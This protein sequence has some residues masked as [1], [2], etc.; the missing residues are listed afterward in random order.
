K[1]R[2]GYCCNGMW[3]SAEALLW[4]FRDPGLPPVASA[5]G[6]GIVGAPTTTTVVEGADLDVNP[7]AGAR[8]SA[9][10]WINSDR[11]MSIE[12][13]GFVT[14][15]GG[16][17]VSLLSTAAQPVFI[18]FL[19][20]ANAESALPTTAGG[21]VVVNGAERLWGVECNFV[22][23]SELCCHDVALFFGYRY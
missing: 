13:T 5:G 12:A 8:A 9:G 17:N 23:L 15:R 7:L 4:W 18:P 3:F 16:G 11:T 22:C 2:A 6:T 20:A 10:F 1:H 21:G 19:T 14:E